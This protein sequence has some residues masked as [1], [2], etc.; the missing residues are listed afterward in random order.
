MPFYK[1]RT[2]HNNTIVAVSGTS[3]TLGANEAQVNSTVIIPSIQ[4]VYLYRVTGGTAV[5]PN[6]DSFIIE[7]LQNV[8]NVDDSSSITLR[9]FTGYTGT[10]APATYLTKSS[11]NTYSGTSAQG[12]LIYKENGVTVNTGTTQLT[13]LNFS[14]GITVTNKGSGAGE[15]KVIYGSEVF[16]TGRTSTQ[17]TTSST[18]A[19]YL[20][21]SFTLAGGTYKI[22]YTIKISN[23]SANSN[24][25]TQLLIDGVSLESGT[26]NLY[27]IGTANQRILNTTFGVQTLSA[28]SHSFRLQISTS[29]GTLT[30]EYG[31]ILITRIA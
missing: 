18:F 15:I 11:F 27:R 28:G 23:S 19:D 24:A 4:P 6:L 12:R 16:N 26:N 29:T 21:H 20:A 3:F 8:D 2:D 13:S 1:Y 31:Q 17:T 22:E 9:T 25:G 14:S 7:F 30:A 5:I 10:T